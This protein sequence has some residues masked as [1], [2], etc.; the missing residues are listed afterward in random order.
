MA[1]AAGAL[2]RK[3]NQYFLLGDAELQAIRDLERPHRTVRAGTEL[4]H[5]RQTNHRAFILKDGWAV[6]YKT[7]PDGSRKSSTS[8]GRA[9]SWG[10]AA[11]CCEPRITASRR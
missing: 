3:L 7:L 6:A 9:T 4:V 2:A 1:V 5:E 8:P 10:C 11:C